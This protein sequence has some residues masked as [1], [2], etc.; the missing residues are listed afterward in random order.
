[1]FCSRCG[2]KMPPKPENVEVVSEDVPPEAVELKETEADKE[3]APQPE[4]KP[5]EEY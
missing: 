2:A 4:T 1:M 3:A 5:S